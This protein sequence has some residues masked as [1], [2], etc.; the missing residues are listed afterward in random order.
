MSMPT[1]VA[2]ERARGP[3]GVPSPQP[4][5]RTHILSVT[6]SD[7]ATA[8]PDALTKAAI[9]VK[10]PFS[11]R[12][13][14]GTGLEN[15]KNGTQG[16]AAAP[17]VHPTRH[18]GAQGVHNPRER[19]IVGQLNGGVRLCR[20]GN[21]CAADKLLATFQF[22]DLSPIFPLRVM[23]RMRDTARRQRE[24]APKVRPEDVAVLFVE[25]T[26]KGSIVHELRLKPD[27]WLAKIPSAWLPVRNRQLVGTR[28]NRLLRPTSALCIVPRC[29]SPSS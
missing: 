27:V 23:R 15:R 1:T 13:H 17:L 12:R 24:D 21:V 29:S 3:A 9:F 6:S 22:Q 20:D 25:P 8:S 2:R 4:R 7:L 26:A 28:T 19:R 14:P 11:H 16:I 5:S 10:F 18:R